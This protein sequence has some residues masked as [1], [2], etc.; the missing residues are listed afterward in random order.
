MKLTKE[1]YS[2]FLNRVAFNLENKGEL[3]VGQ[4]LY[5]ALYWVNPEVALSIAGSEVD[6]FFMDARATA[7]LNK[8]KP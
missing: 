3:R 1:E 2:K 4:V 5:N 8:I 7:F 6:P